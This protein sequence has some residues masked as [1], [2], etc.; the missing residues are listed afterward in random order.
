MYKDPV[1]DIGKRSK[2]G[3][4]ALVRR[5]DGQYGSIREEQLGT[6][7]N[8]LRLVFRDGKLLLDESFEAI[9]VLAA[10]FVGEKGLAKVN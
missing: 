8:H 10:V 2:K 9:R 3:R 5:G 7:F 1:T 4:L 6:R